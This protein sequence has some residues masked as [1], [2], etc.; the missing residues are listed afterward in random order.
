VVKNANWIKEPEGPSFSA[1]IRY[2]GEKLPVALSLEKKDLVITF[3]NPVRG[4]SL[5]QSIVF[6][7]ND[8]VLGGAVMERV[9]S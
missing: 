6:Y 3:S 7:D 2:R 1:R 4:L 5:G 9:V 8:V